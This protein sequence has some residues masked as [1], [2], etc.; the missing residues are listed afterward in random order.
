MMK[1][2]EGDLKV[3]HKNICRVK[4]RYI[5]NEEVKE[6]GYYYIVEYP[7]IGGLLPKVE[8]FKVNNFKVVFINKKATLKQIEKESFFKMLFSIYKHHLSLLETNYKK[9]DE[10]E[11]ILYKSLSKFTEELLKKFFKMEKESY[12]SFLNDILIYNKISEKELKQIFNIF[13]SI[14]KELNKNDN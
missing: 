13:K 11:F 6:R 10:D 7:D 5:K 12:N 2:R 3:F 1:I 14:N 8:L 9:Y 4:L